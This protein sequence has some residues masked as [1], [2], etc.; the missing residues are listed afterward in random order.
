[1]FSLF[2]GGNTGSNPV[3]LFKNASLG[4]FF[5][6]SVMFFGSLQH[7]CSINAKLLQKK[8]FVTQRS[9]FAVLQC[10]H[11]SLMTFS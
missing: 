10:R 5:I 11:E 7:L 2:H 1:M 8:C 6:F 3:R 9:V 4:V